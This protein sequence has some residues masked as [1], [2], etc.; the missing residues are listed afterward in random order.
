MAHPHR[1]TTCHGSC[2][3]ID[4]SSLHLHVEIEHLKQKLAEKENHIITMETNFLTEVD[5]FPNGECAALTE[6]LLLW[7]E[8]Y[9]RLY[10]AHKRIQKVNQNLEDKLLK[11]VDKCETEKFTMNRDIVG[12]K[13]K[14]AEANSTIVCLK[15]D[16]VSYFFDCRFMV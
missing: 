10:E 1:C 15:D 4:H 12:L 16:N 13:H 9:N 3:G 11:I 7:Q 5:K 6:D 8:K 2:N 14:L